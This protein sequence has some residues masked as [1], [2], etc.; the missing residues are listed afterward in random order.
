MI[1]DSK[2][3]EDWSMASCNRR[4]SLS[5]MVRGLWREVKAECCTG[6]IHVHNP[7]YKTTGERYVPRIQFLGFRNRIQCT[8]HIISE[9]LSRVWAPP[10]NL[11]AFLQKTL[12]Y[13]ISRTDKHQ[14]PLVRS[15]HVLLINEFVINLHFFP[16][17]QC[18]ILF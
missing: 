12:I 14:W 13:H 15:H 1:T 3:S 11:S 9:I 5:R 8:H 17:F 6:D 4:T 2:F 18:K 10:Y 16:S 7:L